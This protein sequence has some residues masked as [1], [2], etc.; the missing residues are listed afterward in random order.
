MAYSFAQVDASYLRKLGRRY[1]LNKNTGIALAVRNT[2]PQEESAILRD[3]AQALID[4][5]S[6]NLGQGYALVSKLDVIDRQLA[7][8]DI[9]DAAE[10]FHAFIDQVQTFMSAGTLSV[11][12]GP[13]LIDAAPKR[14]RPIERIE[15]D[16]HDD[17]Q[18]LSS[19][20]GFRCDGVW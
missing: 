18:S 16:L 20:L 7:D 15:H 6:L 12:Q 2:T 5:G 14:H 13:R 17:P 3:F 8:R 19:F 10:L 9:E 11:S 4:D 1:R